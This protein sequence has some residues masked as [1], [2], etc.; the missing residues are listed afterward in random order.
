MSITVY[1]VEITDNDVE[2]E[3]PYHEAA[4]NPVQ[5]AIE[6]LV[7][8]STRP[9][10][11]QEQEITGYRDA[12]NLIHESAGEMAFSVNVILQLHATLNR[13]AHGV[14]GHWKKSDNQ[15]VERNREGSI[16]HVRFRAVSAV[17]TPRA[18]NN[19][20]ALYALAAADEHEPFIVIPLA[21]LDFLCIHP[22][23]DGNGRMARLLTL[24]L[25]HRADFVVG[26]YISLERVIEESKE[27]YYEALAA[28]SQG[29]HAGKHDPHPWINYFWGVL[30]AACREFEQRVGPFKNASGAKSTLI[31][32]AVR[33][34]FMAFS[35]S[36]IETECPGV[37]RDMVRHVL[38]H[39]KTRGEIAVRGRGR[40]AKWVRLDGF[41]PKS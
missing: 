4:A 6:A 34:R 14:G 40:G 16:R 5:A 24:L 10:N 13:R 8:R 37:S 39:M 33:R 7:L 19:L 1:G 9:A 29:W 23:T 41:T 27:T 3:L 18:M 12:L 38:R 32:G 20:A 25:L 22:F 36:D 26:R 35:I 21:I 15:I 11:R 17:R 31:V 30:I 2:R 28:S